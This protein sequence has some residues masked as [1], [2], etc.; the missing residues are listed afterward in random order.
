MN[1][2]NGKEQVEVEIMI[3]VKYKFELMNMENRLMDIMRNVLIKMGICLLVC[4][5]VLLL[6]KRE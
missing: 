2:L 6:K 3:E 4:L 5:I 1:Y